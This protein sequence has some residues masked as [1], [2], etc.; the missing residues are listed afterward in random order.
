M[1][2]IYPE[3]EEAQVA[4]LQTEH[5]D[6]MYRYQFSGT[7]GLICCPMVLKD[8]FFLFGFGNWELVNTQ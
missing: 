3:P 6:N 4:H 2:L 5:C 1:Q 8:Y 7:G